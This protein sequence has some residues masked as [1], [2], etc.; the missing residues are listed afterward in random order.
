MPN[1]T[2]TDELL[3]YART[4]VAAGLEVWHSPFDRAGY[5][6]YRDPATDCWG[7]FQESFSEG[8]QHLMP[9][10]PSRENGSSM[11]IGGEHR[12]Y[13]WTVE[14]AR[15]CARPRNWNPLVGH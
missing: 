3:A 4:L 14:A 10:K 6:L 15:E 1:Q 8:W 2:A 11:F 5:L 9:I 7:S 12:V 13:P